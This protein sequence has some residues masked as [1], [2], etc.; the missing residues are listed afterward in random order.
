MPA[1]TSHR[2]APTDPAFV[3]RTLALVGAPS[4]VA[5]G[6]RGTNLGPEALRVAGLETALTRMGYTVR[7]Q[8][9]VAGP[10]NPLKPAVDG[11]R[12]FD[13]TL[14]WCRVVRDAVAD[15]LDRDATP[16]L[17]G[18]DHSLSI[19]SVA[20][21]ARHCDRHGIPLSVLW[22][23][24]H[25]DFNTHETSPSGN[26]HGMPVAVM[27]G[28]GHADLLDLGHALPMIDPGRVHQVGIRSVDT[29]ERRRIVERGLRVH[30]MRRID[31]RGMRTVMA[32]VL[33]TI[34]R[35]GG[36]LHVSFDLDFVDPDVAPGVGTPVL[37]GPTWR[38]AQLC[39][40][41]IHD[42]GLLGSLDVVE[43]NPALD[44]HNRTAELAVAL[45]KSLFGET[46][47]AKVV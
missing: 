2:N 21:V 14:A 13:E 16:I 4:D 39:M 34:A 27:C 45:V 11:W 41:M 29:V 22:L 32:E 35:T 6:T 38:E 25:A 20:A 3:A 37:G 18:G 12:H 8:G 36:H 30:D 5:A 42:S 31:E 17:M 28:D 26:V 19:G 10:T 9:N 7:D 44:I 33:D 1:A 43:I 40:E 47:L 46:I 15:A 23:D 24:A